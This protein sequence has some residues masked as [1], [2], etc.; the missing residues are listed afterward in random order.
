MERWTKSFGGF[1]VEQYHGDKGTRMQAKVCWK[2]KICSGYLLRF[3]C[4]LKFFQKNL[5]VTLKIY[6]L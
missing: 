5:F 6:N 3:F 2:K 4:R 1:K